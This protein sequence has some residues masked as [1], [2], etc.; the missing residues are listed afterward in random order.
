M[1]ITVIAVLLSYFAYASAVT[2]VQ[3]CPEGK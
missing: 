1:R 3:Q 2:P